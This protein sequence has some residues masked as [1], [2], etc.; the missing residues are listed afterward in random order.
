MLD[1][2]GRSRRGWQRMRWLDGII[3]SMSLNKLQEIVKDREVWHAAVHGVT[4]SWRWLSNWTET[5]ESLRLCLDPSDNQDKR[6]SC[7]TRNWSDKHIQHL[8]FPEQKLLL[9][10]CRN[11]CLVTQSCLTLCNPMHCSPPCSPSLS[12]GILQARML[13]WL[14]MS[15]SRWSSQPRDQTQVFHVAGGFFTIWVTREALVG[16]W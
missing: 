13:E 8:S 14:A 7:H 16:T 11:M 2:E 5:S 6:T 12:M 4:K 10:L 9:Y 1:T 15:S 3:D